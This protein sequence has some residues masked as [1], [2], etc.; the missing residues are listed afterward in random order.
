MLHLEIVT[1]E[2]VSFNGMV[3][4]LTVPSSEGTLGIFPRHASLFAQL[5][6]GEV[7]I[8]QGKDELYLSIGGGFVE[9]TGEKV[10]L[11]VTRAVNAMELQE[12]AILKAQQEAK[13]ALSKQVTSEERRTAQ[14]IFRRS[15]IDLKLYRKLQSKQV[16]H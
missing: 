13:E 16:R 14:L 3:E 7:K 15:L 2:R 1:P 4:G 12:Q 10:V 5:V 9:V 6:D 11:L 8:N